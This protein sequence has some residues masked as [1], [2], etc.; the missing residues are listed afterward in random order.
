MIKEGIIIA[1]FVFYAFVISTLVRDIRNQLLTQERKTSLNLSS[2]SSTT[3]K[4]VSSLSNKWRTL[5]PVLSMMAKNSWRSL[6][7]T[8]VELTSTNLQISWPRNQV[9]VFWFSAQDGWEMCWK[10]SDSFKSRVSP[11]PPS[12]FPPIY[13]PLPTGS[14][15]TL[16]TPQTLNTV[17]T[18]YTQINPPPI[19]KQTKKKTFLQTRVRRL[20]LS[21]YGRVSSTWWFP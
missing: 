3:M 11:A 20:L 5:M 17:H 12:P 16:Q 21:A 13:Q 9:T 14:I 6:D 18:I 4:M 15:Q 1:G 7:N 8:D 10:H 19:K 2:G